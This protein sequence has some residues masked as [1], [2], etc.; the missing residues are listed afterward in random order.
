MLTYTVIK[1]KLADSVEAEIDHA[2]SLCLLS[3]GS[4]DAL[5]AV[6]HMTVLTWEQGR[7]VLL[8]FPVSHHSGPKVCLDMPFPAPL[9]PATPSTCL[10]KNHSSFKSHTSR[11]L[12]KD[13]AICFAVVGVN[14]YYISKDACFLQWI[15]SISGRVENP[16]SLL[17]CKSFNHVL[18]QS[19]VLFINPQLFFSVY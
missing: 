5:T 14:L 10:Q 8:P 1:T 4:S 2:E 12:W 3:P 6:I 13:A 18:I 19:L 15:K 11:D 16:P 17:R 7:G 9:S